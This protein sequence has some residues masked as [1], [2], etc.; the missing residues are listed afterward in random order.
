MLED[1]I[2]YDVSYDKLPLEY[3]ILEFRL[4][5]NRGLYDDKVITLKEYKIMEENILGRMN[6]IKSKQV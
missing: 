2:E 6:K 1:N 4:F 3:K 5:I